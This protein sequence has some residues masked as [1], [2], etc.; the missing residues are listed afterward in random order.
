VKDPVRERASRR[1][2]RHVREQVR[3]ADPRLAVDVDDAALLRGGENDAGL[4]LPIDVLRVAARPR[5][6]R[7]GQRDRAGDLT[8]PVQQRTVDSVELDLHVDVVAGDDDAVAD[9][10]GDGDAPRARRGHQGRSVWT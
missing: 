8:E 1:I 7:N 10:A 2:V 4:T 5:V 3:L 9:V 6:D